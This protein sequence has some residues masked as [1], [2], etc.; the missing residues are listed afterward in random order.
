M[1]EAR[2]E[3]CREGVRGCVGKMS[4]RWI[5]QDNWDI[6]RQEAYSCEQLRVSSL[7]T[8]HVG[9][10]LCCVSGRNISLLLNSEI[11]YTRYK[12]PMLRLPV[13]VVTRVVADKTIHT[14]RSGSETKAGNPSRPATTRQYVVFSGVSERLVVLV[15]LGAHTSHPTP[16]SSQPAQMDLA[17][18]QIIYDGLSHVCLPFTRQEWPSRSRN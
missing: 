1:P 18:P 5:D 14:G 12:D 2:D 3:E 7:S 6:K 4:L 9:G 17:W 8:R 10:V 13:A 11:L 16:K 15:R